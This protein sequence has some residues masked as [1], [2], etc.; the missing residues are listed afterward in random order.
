MGRCIGLDVGS[1]RIGIAVSDE[2]G[3][4]ATPRGAI[5]RSTLRR[6][7]AALSELIEETAAEVIVIG[8]PVGMA[9]APTAQTHQTERFAK[10]LSQ[11][12]EVRIELW[13]ERL[14][15]AMAEAITGSDPRT[16]RSGRRDAVAAAFILQGYLDHR[17]KPPLS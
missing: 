8:Y 5:D 7:L 11:E 2:L 14:T 12:T 4:L 17:E 13:D 16:R 9:G 15:T 10:M 3:V 6:D 1:K